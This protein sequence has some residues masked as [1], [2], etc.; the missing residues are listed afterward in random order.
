[1]QKN[2]PKPAVADYSPWKTLLIGT[3]VSILFTFLVWLF[4]STAY[5]YQSGAMARSLSIADIILGSVLLPLGFYSRWA[6][7][8]R[9]KYHRWH[10]WLVNLLGSMYVCLLLLLGGI[11]YWNILLDKP[12][13]WFVNTVIVILWILALLLPAISATLAKHIAALQD[14]LDL[15]ILQ[16]GGPTVLL[17]LSGILGANFGL[18]G[19]IDNKITFLAFIFP[20]LSI[21]LAQYFSNYLWSY[22]P[23]AGEDE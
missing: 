1:M 19:S 16:F 6:W 20:V 7:Q 21:G 5:L 9:R 12:W 15:K 10:R 13:S 11:T 4:N 2:F 18:K 3:G 8:P 17:I 14:R 22:R 23:W